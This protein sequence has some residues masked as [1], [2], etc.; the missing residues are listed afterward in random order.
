[1]KSTLAYRSYSLFISI[2]VCMLSCISSHPQFNAQAKNSIPTGRSNNSRRQTSGG[3]VDKESEK[4]KSEVQKQLSLGSIYEDN[5]QLKEA[6]AAYVIALDNAT[7]DM[8]QKIIEFLRRVV[9]KQ[10]SLRQLELGKIYEDKGQMKEA[11]AAYSKALENASPE[12]QQ[13]AIVSLQ[14]VIERQYS[15][16]RKY[17]LSPLE[18]VFQAVVTTTGTTLGTILLAFLGGT[19]LFVIFWRPANWIG[20][21]RGR[22]ILEIT[23]LVDSTENKLGANFREIIAST[24]ERFQRL[25]DP[26]GNIGIGATP[27]VINRRRLI[28]TPRLPFITLSQQY[29]IPE[30]TELIATG[31]TGKVIALLT[32]KTYQPEFSIQGSIKSNGANINI[33]I[34]LSRYG[35]SILQKE[36]TFS[37]ANLFDEE[38]DL[39]FDVL[40]FLK[41]YTRQ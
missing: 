20:K 31:G 18:S 5:G 32:K 3:V 11:E 1:M 14:R 21:R 13:K 36:S 37:A 15:P 34:I 41:E 24:L 39:T 8:Q 22:N 25:E 2:I 4:K 10:I 26:F 12:I 28:P 33:I 29:E 35:K 16:G 40:N 6:A 23:P 27:A 7:P 30:L 19:V 17:L 9:E 38:R